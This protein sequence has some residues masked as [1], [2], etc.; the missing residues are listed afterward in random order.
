MTVVNMFEVLINP[1]MK[2]GLVQPQ[3]V[4][5]CKVD[6]RIGKIVGVEARKCSTIRTKGTVQNV[7]LMSSAAI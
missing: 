5:V 1:L 6:T 2:C 7:E 4:F 3:V